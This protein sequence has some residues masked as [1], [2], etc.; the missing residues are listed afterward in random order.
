MYKIL[1]VMVR[2]T[3]TA[4]LNRS[5]GKKNKRSVASISDKVQNTV[6]MKLNYTQ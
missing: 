2:K 1:I 3:N 6:D 5:T 4:L